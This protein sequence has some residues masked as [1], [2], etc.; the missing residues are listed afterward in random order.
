MRNPPPRL[1]KLTDHMDESQPRR[2][3]RHKAARV[4][5]V[6]RIVDL[7]GG[8]H[9]AA[10]AFGVQPAAVSWWCR[11]GHVPSIHQETVLLAGWK[12]RIALGPADFF[13]PAFLETLKIPPSQESTTH[14]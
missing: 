9:R 1:K 3:R 8:T 4:N 2:R 11:R 10:E 12:C 7:F 14:G 5:P 13:D 6:T